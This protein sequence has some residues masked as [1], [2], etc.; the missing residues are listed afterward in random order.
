MSGMAY[1]PN[2]GDHRK[3]ATAAAFDISSTVLATLTA[4]SAW[5]PLPFLQEA[6]LLALTILNTVQAAKDNKEAFKSLA[7]D[8]CELVSAIICVY[9]DLEKEGVAP[10]PNLKKNVED[11][12][13][14]LKAINQFAVKHVGKGPM[15]RIV[16]MQSENQ[17]ISQYRAKLK[18]ALT[19]FGIQSSISIHETVVQILKELRER[20]QAREKEGGSDPSSGPSP[21]P[22]DSPFANLSRGNIT[23]NITINTVHGDQVFNSTHRRTH[24]VDSFNGRSFNSEQSWS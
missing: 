9:N 4:A 11:L 24:I 14:L 20:D 1:F 18:Q 2:V 22:S 13:N 7:N 6:S 5:A 23:G 10:S 17:K 19:V 16:R 15:Y 21:I 3:G 12:I 8:A